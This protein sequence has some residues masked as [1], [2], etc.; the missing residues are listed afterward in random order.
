MLRPLRHRKLSYA[1]VVIVVFLLFKCKIVYS[2]DTFDSDKST[3]VDVGS[4]LSNTDDEEQHVLESSVETDNGKKAGE[5]KSDSGGKNPDDDIETLDSLPETS[6]KTTKP[7]KADESPKVPQPKGKGAL[8][9]P[10][11]GKL[12]DYDFTNYECLHTRFAPT[13]QKLQNDDYTLTEARLR[14][15]RSEFLYCFF[16]KGGD[17]GNGD[18]QHDIHS[19]VPQIHKNFN[20]QLPFFGFRYNYTRL[21][22]N[23]Y[24]EFSDPPEHYTYPLVFP[25][26]DWPKKND[27][28]FIGIFFSKCRIGM[29]RTDDID[30]K[31][32][33]VYFRME[34]DLQA[35]KDQF[36]VEMRERLKWDV[37]EGVIGAETFDP[38]H[39]VVVTWKNMSFAGGIDNSLYRTNTFQL[40]LATDEVFTYAIFNYVNLM[41]SSHTEA[42]GDTTTGEGGVPA[43]IG[44]N[45]GNGTQS[46]EYKPY[47]QDSVLRDLVG[48]GWTNGFPGRH[49]FRIDE[50][51]LVGNCNKDICTFDDVTVSGTVVD[52]NRAICVQPFIMAE[53]YVRFEIATGTSRFNWKGKFFVGLT[54]SP[55]LWSKPIPLAWYFSPQWERKWGSRWSE[56]LCNEWITDDRYLK[57]FA[58]EVPQCPCTLE[59]A[60]MDKG[61]FLPD[62]DCDKDANP[63]CF[64]HKGAVHCVRSGAPRFLR[65]PTGFTT[66]H[67]ST[68]AVYGKKSKLLAVKHSDLNAGLLRIVLLISPPLLL[69]YTI[70]NFT[71]AARD[72]A[73][74]IIEVR[75]RPKHAQWRYHLDVLADGKKV[76][77]DRPSLRIQHFP[78]VTVYM[79]TYILNQSEIVIMFESGAGV[80]VVENEGFMTTRVYLPWGFMN[81]TRGLFGNWSHDVLDDFTLPD[82]FLAG[83]ST[84][85]LN[86]V[87]TLHKSFALK[88]IIEDKE[89][90][91][92]GVALF[93][94]EFGKTA[95]SYANKTFEPEYRMRAQDIIPSNRTKDYEMAVKLCG[96]SYQCL[97]DYAMSLNRDMAHFTKNYLDSFTQIK[98]KNKERVISCGVLETPRFGRKSTFLFVPGTKVTFECNQDFILIGDQRR[99][100]TEQ[101]KWDTPE[102]GYTECL[103]QQE[104]S[105][106]QIGITFGIILGVLVP[107]I[108]IG[109]FLA[110]RYF[111]R[112]KV[113][114]GSTA[115]W[116]Y[117]SEPAPFK[118]AA[119]PD[120]A[121]EPFRSSAMSATSGVSDRSDRS[122]SGSSSLGGFKKRRMYDRSYRTHEPVPGQPLVDFED[123][124]WDVGEED[125]T[126]IANTSVAGSDGAP[127]DLSGKAVYRHRQQ[128]YSSRQAGITA[129]IVMA[130]VVPILLGLVCVAYHVL[131]KRKNEDNYDV[132]DGKMPG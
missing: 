108:L 25:V 48:R 3:D 40:V 37:R 35:R 100:C 11:S 20:F 129:G 73:S 7:K 94:R 22:M 10:K 114:D 109:V 99:V 110:F 98:A 88:W 43:F 60:L 58:A 127:S 131:V 72:N 57:N 74:A 130:V 24:L 45:G 132:K 46:Y 87:E 105:S 9:E 78:G 21:S 29:V 121:F 6:T 116:N 81:Q 97:Y 90:P 52:S 50:K 64:Y 41:W 36:G 118:A 92:K 71:F 16:D 101:G 4:I 15:I 77:F 65:S 66:W 80:E 102:F 51:I 125:E 54:V 120:R 1:F 93:T 111:K 113:D 96:D 59:H 55:V 67:L 128:E 32:A 62:F 69:R 14:Q 119:A 115:S 31:K 18:Y 39:A 112:N 75:L 23:G 95:S 2:L 68:C 28:A 106:R 103:R 19:S 107:I 12:D 83:V 30:Q 84:G 117:K 79:P 8:T 123:R 5:I 38:K 76:F 82:G 104:Y 33:G 89:D 91:E 53:G 63:N 61:R 47:S 42:G 13:T 85:T 86:N 124:L 44:F 27:P 26:K 17:D 70:F 126:G 34:R 49:I 122:S 56:E